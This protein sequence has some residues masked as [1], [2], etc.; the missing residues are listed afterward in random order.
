MI[1]LLFK[2]YIDDARFS[3]TENIIRE[4][5]EQRNIGG[6]L[7]TIICY[8]TTSSKRAKIVQHEL[9]GKVSLDEV[10]RNVHKLLIASDQAVFNLEISF[11]TFDKK[12]NT[13]VQILDSNQAEVRVIEI[14]NNNQTPHFE[15]ISADTAWGHLHIQEEEK[16]GLNKVPMAFIV[17]STIFVTLIFYLLLYR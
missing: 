16:E 11:I 9:K 5:F 3:Q 4:F 12:F 2:N 15:L 8:A 13:A 17:I 14:T 1:S 6:Y 7:N 10:F